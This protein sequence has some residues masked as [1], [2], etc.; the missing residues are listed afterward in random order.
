[1]KIAVV[2]ATGPTGQEVVAQGLARGHEVVAYVRRPA[3][4]QS[5][6]KLTVIGGQL[7][8]TEKFATA[9]A[10]C[11]VLICTL[12]TRSFKERNFMSVHIPM[13]SDAMKKAGLNRMVLMG[14][15]GGG[16]V[17]VNAYWFSKKMFKF[18]SKYIFG[19]RTVCEDALDKTGI[20]WAAVYPAFLTNGPKLSNPDVVDMNVLKDVWGMQISRATVASTLLDLA[21]DSARP[22][23]KV[24]VTA[25][26]KIKI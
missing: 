26:G 17:P 21:E 5:A 3:A 24:A 13:V 4:L 20:N 7:E 2:G 25:P 19:D 16:E 22:T 1:M 18:M 6:A 23:R 12:G 9:I 10:D 14:A 8:E 11:D 15:L